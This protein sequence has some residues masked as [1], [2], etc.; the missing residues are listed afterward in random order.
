MI[1]SLALIIIIETNKCIFI[2]I[3]KEKE[4]NILVYRRDLERAQRAKVAEAQ[5]PKET[6]VLPVTVVI[7]L[8]RGLVPEGT[9]AHTFMK[10]P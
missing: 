7:G 2:I 8:R 10:T 6:E 5:P 3:I 1:V 9:R 4:L